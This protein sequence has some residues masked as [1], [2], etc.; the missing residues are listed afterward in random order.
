MIEETTYEPIDH[1]M[2]IN[3]IRFIEAYRLNHF[4]NKELNITKRISKYMEILGEVYPNTVLWYKRLY[5][6]NSQKYDEQMAYNYNYIDMMNRKQQE[7][8]DYIVSEV[9]NGVSYT[10]KVEEVVKPKRV[11]KPAVKK[12]PVKRLKIKK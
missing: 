11:R 5:N 2:D 4:T 7:V 8:K 3:I 6:K 9:D 12:A 10:K 1:R